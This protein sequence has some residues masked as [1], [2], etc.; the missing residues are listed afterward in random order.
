MTVHRREP[1]E[2]DLNQ[3]VFELQLILV[4]PTQ[5]VLITPAGSR[6]A[7]TPPPGNVKQGD[8]PEFQPGFVIKDLG[9]LV[10]QRMGLSG[11]TRT[12]QT[13]RIV[14][15]GEYLPMHL[16]VIAMCPRAPQYRNANRY[17]TFCWQDLRN[18]KGESGAF[19]KCWF[20]L[21]SPSWHHGACCPHNPAAR[22]WNG[23]P[24][25]SV[26]HANMQRFIRTLPF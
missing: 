16:P 11:Y 10:R 14:H 6:I 24:H 2:A 12:S 17:C 9:I 22:E 4:E 8:S 15:Q 13:T 21:D 19:R 7:V 25:R 18:K 3:T 5:A 20:C 1:E 26:H 23:T